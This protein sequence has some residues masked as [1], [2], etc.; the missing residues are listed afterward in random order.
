M[1][2]Y[3]TIFLISYILCI[4]DFVESR[5]GKFC[6]YL[7][8][9][10]FITLIVG[11]REVGIDNDSE[12]YQDMFDF[13]RTSTFMQIIEGGYGYVEK[14]YVFL[15]KII[16]L[17]GGNHRILF[18]F[19]AIFTAL[20]NYVFFW[21]KSS[22]VFLSILFYL[23]FFY[24]YRDFTQIRYGLS[25]AICM[26][27]I[28]LFLSKKY[29]Q[30]L[31]IILVAI[32]F[33]NAAFIL[34][35]AVF[36]AKI[37]KNQ[38]W[39]ILIPIPCYFIGKLLTLQLVFSLLGYNADHMSIYLKDESAGSASISM[40]GYCICLLYYFLMNYKARFINLNSITIET[41]NYYYK[42]VSIAVA[43]NFL[44]INISIFQRFSFIMFQFCSILIAMTIELMANR[45]RERYLFILYYFL[46]A[47]FLLFYG[48]RMINE[49]L[50]RPYIFS[51]L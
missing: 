36:I 21:K 37:F 26:W 12:A 41:G 4:F 39:Y 45:I 49:D 2:L 48:V 17:V 8:F 50:V 23:S 20:L 30:S 28:S 1:I 24:L 5:L 43:M 19:V 46:I 33:H 44:F 42:L 51:F 18:L 38:L 3:Y 16:S 47:S 22:Y 9:C 13:Y 10:T 31:I 40:V 15:N 27:A 35:L 14:G 25:A 11:L 7:A 29:F 34:L 32:S 6:V